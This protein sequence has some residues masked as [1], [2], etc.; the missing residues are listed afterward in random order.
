[1]DDHVEIDRGVAAVVSDRGYRHHRNEDAG[2]VIVVGDRVAVVVCD[3]V[4]STANPDQAAEAAAAAAAG[5]LRSFLAEPAPGAEATAAALR[6][7]VSTARQ[8]VED[9]PGSEPGGYPGKP[10][11][12]LVLGVIGPGTAIM[13]SVGDSR[14]YWLP[15][16]GIN[17]RVTVDD[18][19]AEAAIATG[20]PEP[21]AYAA[22]QA[23]VI[24]NW[25]GGDSD[26]PDLAVALVH[27]DRPGLL[28]VCSDG[29]W[30]Y[31][32]GPDELAAAAVE[33][34]SP[35]PKGASRPLTVARHLVDVALR[36]GGADNVTVAV[37]TAGPGP[38]GPGSGGPSFA[39]P[40]SAGAE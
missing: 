29:L 23:H 4:S 11:T 38:D 20:V 18:S 32:P 2:E 12:T 9:V 36:S 3:G 22:P 17:R 24:T 34:V 39:G 31:L 7:A 13:A 27:L 37:V 35:A 28:V 1:M 26:R 6:Q 8:A 5:V 30:N 21:D 10:S 33:A 25:I 15:D 19:W 16:E 14:G 40:G